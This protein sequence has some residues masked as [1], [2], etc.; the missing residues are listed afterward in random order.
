MEKKKRERERENERILFQLKATGLFNIYLVT[1]PQRDQETM[2][3]R[4]NKAQCL[5]L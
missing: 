1:R 5:F 4:S 3:S 2:A